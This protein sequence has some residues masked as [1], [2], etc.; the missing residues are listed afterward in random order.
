MK[1]APVSSSR[2]LGSS[3]KVPGHTGL[4]NLGNTCY[5]NS[6]LQALLRTEPLVD[7]FL[8]QSYLKVT[9]F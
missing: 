8:S 9:F 1:T 3:Q 5:L 4:D 2:F 7:Y 6:S